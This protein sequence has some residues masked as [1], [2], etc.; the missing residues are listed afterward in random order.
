MSRE[1]DA[2]GRQVETEHNLKWRL[3]VIIRGSPSG[4][5]LDSR[6]KRHVE[7]IQTLE[8]TIQV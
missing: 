2:P 6:S 4:K 7:T 5:F 1:P 3:D 8:T